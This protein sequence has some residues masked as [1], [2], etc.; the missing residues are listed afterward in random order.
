VQCRFPQTA[1]LDKNASF[2]TKSELSQRP[3]PAPIHFEIS[4]SCFG[5]SDRTQER[6][7]VPNFK[8]FRALAHLQ[9][10][11][12][13]GKLDSGSKHLI[14]HTGNVLN[15]NEIKKKAGQTLTEEVCLIFM[16]F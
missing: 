15:L 6:R 14:I 10:R 5:A 8:Y 1:S 11:T 3:P 13:I 12:M 2:A 4:W 16:S 7:K 9:T